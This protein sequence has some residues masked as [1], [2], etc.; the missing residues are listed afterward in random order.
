[1]FKKN[2]GWILSAALVSSQAHGQYMAGGAGVQAS[3]YGGAQGQWG[4]GFYGAQQ[5]CMVRAGA[6]A[7][8]QSDEMSEIKDR[9]KE[10]REELAEKKRTLRGLGTKTRKA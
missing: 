3:L 9:Q 10:L 8:S 1:M 6:G 4:S 7:I 2:M 5:P